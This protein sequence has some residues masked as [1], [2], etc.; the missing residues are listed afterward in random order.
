MNLRKN[1]PL[2]IMDYYYEALRFYNGLERDLN[3]SFVSNIKLYKLFESNTENIDWIN[4]HYR[5]PYLVSKA[6]YNSIYGINNNF[7]YGQVKQAMR[8]DFEE[9]FYHYKDKLKKKN[10][11]LEEDFDH[12]QLMNSKKKNTY[13]DIKFDKICFCEGFGINSN[14]FFKD[15]DILGKKG[16]YLIIKSEKLKQDISI[17]EKFFILPLGNNLFKVGATY[18]KDD[19]TCNSTDKSR[20]DIEVF[21]KR[22]L[23]VPYSIDSQI[24]GIRTNTKTK[25]ALILKHNK[26]SNYYV[27]NGF[28]SKGFLIAPYL[29]KQF[30][31]FF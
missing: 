29:S 7:G 23:K 11:F 14:P 18:I 21:L 28:G 15:L 9:L 20:Y 5:F 2:D 6:H 19:Y 30:V 17:K 3:A 8:I 13:K 10:I 4:S 25:E 26:F 22:T 1:I 27:F 12:H 31:M 24:A 16:E